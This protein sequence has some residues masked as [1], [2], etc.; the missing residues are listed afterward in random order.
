MSID[1]KCVETQNSYNF[2]TWRKGV[3]I[4]VFFCSPSGV[5]GVTWDFKC[6]KSWTRNFELRIV[7][8][9]QDDLR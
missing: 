3:Q 2:G 1:A 8:M 6:G 7:D 9:V 4:C 5:S